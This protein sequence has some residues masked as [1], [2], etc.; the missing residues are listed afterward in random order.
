MPAME[1]HQ[2]VGY[3]LCA[4]ASTGA[5]V[6]ATAVHLRKGMESMRPKKMIRQGTDAMSWMPGLLCIQ[7]AH[8]T[9]N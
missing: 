3:T 2:V 5:G 7:R 1:V 6:Q 8:F 9:V 4:A